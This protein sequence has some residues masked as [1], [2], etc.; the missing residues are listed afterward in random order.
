MNPLTRQRDSLVLCPTI[1]NNEVLHMK[2]FIARLVILSVVL[3]VPALPLNAQTSSDSSGKLIGNNDTYQKLKLTAAAAP[4]T[5]HSP[6]KCVKAV[7]S[8]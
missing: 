2:D 8:D 5:G 4:A 3:I 1:E 6:E 7:P